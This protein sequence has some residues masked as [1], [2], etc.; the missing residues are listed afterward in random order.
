MKKLFTK[1]T[2]MILLTINYAYS[3]SDVSAK[4]I[5]YACYSCHG[6]KIINLNKL[7]TISAIEL[8]NILLA[9]KTNQKNATI[10]DRISKGFTDGEL[11]AVAI[12]LS[13]NP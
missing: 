11:K 6:K 8:T 4:M 2:I 5:A 7:Q 9:F 1:I 12:Y 13:N 3:S 10:M